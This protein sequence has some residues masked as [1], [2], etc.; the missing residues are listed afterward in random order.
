MSSVASTADALRIFVGYTSFRLRAIA[1][2][3]SAMTTAGSR[4]GIRNAL[5]L[6]THGHSIVQLLTL[7][8]DP[9]HHPRWLWPLSP[10]VCKPSSVWSRPP[11][12]A[13]AGHTLVTPG[14]LRA[15][16]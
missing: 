4:I 2:W 12:G 15:R 5:F 10:S 16:P 11:H 6:P 8:P 14:L 13:A 3:S 1:A 7:L 9:W